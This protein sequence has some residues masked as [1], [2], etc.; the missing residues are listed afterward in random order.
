MFLHDFLDII[1]QIKD[2]YR[3]NDQWSIYLLAHQTAPST[4][5]SVLLLPLLYHESLQKLLEVM[6]EELSPFLTFVFVGHFLLLCLSL[7]IFQS[8]VSV[9]WFFLQIR[10]ADISGSLSFWFV[11]SGFFNGCLFEFW[12]LFGEGK[13]QSTS[14][15]RNIFEFLPCKA[16]FFF[17]ILYQIHLKFSCW[18]DA[19]I[20]NS[21][22]N[23]LSFD[24]QFFKFRNRRFLILFS[25]ITWLPIWIL[26]S[27]NKLT[28]LI[29]SET[30]FSHLF[31]K[32]LSNSKI[33]QTDLPEPKFLS[34]CL[35]ISDWIYLINICKLNLGERHFGLFVSHPNY[36]I[37]ID[38]KIIRKR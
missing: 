18:L 10:Q 36:L 23:K 29:K 37:V 7:S 19:I 3:I 24:D 17:F 22:V 4:Y 1:E 5:R 33:P 30:S 14:L 20:L 2:S 28:N 32:H 27:I 38:F 35:T 11:F 21:I 12:L 26:F 16:I 34:Q 9:W 13:T 8:S 15:T 25:L 6:K 31:Q